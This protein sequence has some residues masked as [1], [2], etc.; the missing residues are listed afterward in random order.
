M[1]F[2]VHIEWMGRTDSSKALTSSEPTF[3]IGI[4][5]CREF[6]TIIASCSEMVFCIVR[7]LFQPADSASTLPIA[8]NKTQKGAMTAQANF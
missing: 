7:V 2:N 4:S 6:I 3:S 8:I 1:A 5:G